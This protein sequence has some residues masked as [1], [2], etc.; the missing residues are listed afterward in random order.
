MPRPE[1]GFPVVDWLP[2][3]LPVAFCVIIVELHRVYITTQLIAVSSY[4]F[5]TWLTSFFHQFVYWLTSFL[6]SLSKRN[7][8]YFLALLSLSEGGFTTLLIALDYYSG[9]WSS[10]GIP[11][12][13]SS[14]FHGSSP[15]SMLFTSKSKL[16]VDAFFRTA[17]MLTSS[18]HL[19][20]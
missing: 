13:L 14:I 8:I 7:I 18:C 19:P 17:V 10:S 9:S 12:G 11:K 2:G 1:D 6:T 15:S 5:L 4:L 20:S 3:Y 16:F